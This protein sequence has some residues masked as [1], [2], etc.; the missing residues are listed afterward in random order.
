MQVFQAYR[1]GL[2]LV[3]VFMMGVSGCATSADRLPKPTPTP[4]NMVKD[5]PEAEPDLMPAPAPVITTPPPVS[6]ALPPKDDPAPHVEIPVYESPLTA[7][8]SWQELDHRPALSAV[9]R[10]CQRWSHAAVTDYLNPHL[11]D[12]GTYGDWGDTCDLAL[13]LGN[14]KQEAKQFFENQFVPVMLLS[15]ANETG[16]LTGYYQPEIS[17]RRK[18]DTV[19]S[20]PILAVPA[21]QLVQNYP[22]GKLG[23]KSSRVI[24]YGR[25][26]DVF[27]MQIQ[28]SGIIRFKDGKRIRAAYN[29]NNGFP[30][31]SIGRVL[32]GRGAIGKDQSSK[33]DIEK[34]MAVAGPIKSRALMNENKRYI[35]FKEQA[36]K[37]GEGPQG[38]MQVPLT[39]IGSMA[40]DPRYHPYG[41]VAYIQTRIPQ[42][43]GDYKGRETAVLLVA[44]DTGKA[45]KGA[46][47]GDLYFGSGT[48]A[49]D[50]AGVMKHPAHWTILLPRR[51]ADRLAQRATQ[52][53]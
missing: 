42:E 7:L 36:I 20:E 19:F 17:V 23:A 32:I 53:S 49:G 27:F 43:K 6:S 10:S 31:T 4:I 12:Y 48:D 52:T 45:I 50:R 3:A 22:R 28:G 24:A 15:A 35:F 39:D 41:T 21:Q 18:A 34:W 33:S 16:L 14:S 5:M 46:F 29:G 9:R 44:Q 13:L 38:A 51:L 26:I 8:P 47:R 11:P 2:I 30:Y 37:P 40:V 25:P 1:A